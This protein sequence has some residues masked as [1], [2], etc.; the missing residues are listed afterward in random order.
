MDRGALDAASALRIAHGGWCPAGRLAENGLIPAQYALRETISE[1]H[2]QR[3]RKNVF[4][5]DATLIL[6]CG[7][8]TG[9]TELTLRLAHKYKKP[10]LVV[11]LSCS[12]NPNL[13][14][15]WL[16]KQA[17]AVLNVAGPRESHGNMRYLLTG[18][19]VKRPC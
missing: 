9:G 16:Q 19:K 17:V 3:T 15:Q 18:N 12:P 7:Q 4:E 1:D 6:C 2:T 8:L 13:V 14:W 11:D 5:A 10:C